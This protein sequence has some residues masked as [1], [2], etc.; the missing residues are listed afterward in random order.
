MEWLSN[1]LQTAVVPFDSS[2]CFRNRYGT[3]FN[4]EPNSSPELYQKKV[5]RSKCEFIT[6]KVKSACRE[7]AIDRLFR[8][9]KNG[10]K[11]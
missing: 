5:C 7:N 11:M 10:K 1:E 2:N 8:R 3:V 4:G 9:V 6:Y